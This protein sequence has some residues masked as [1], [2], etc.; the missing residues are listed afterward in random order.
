MLGGFRYEVRH[1]TV[2][3]DVEVCVP[4]AVLNGGVY[5]TQVRGFDD[6]FR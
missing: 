1:N 6:H 2:Q 5:F 4:V 3:R